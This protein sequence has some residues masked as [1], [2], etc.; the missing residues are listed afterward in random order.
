MHRSAS[1]L[2]VKRV[3]TATAIGIASALAC[4]SSLA[5][6]GTET[7]AS[8]AGGAEV[9][10]SAT[11][12]GAG[13]AFTDVITFDGLLASQLYE[14]SLDFSGTNFGA[15]AS[16]TLTGASSSTVNID[17]FS[18]FVF[19]YLEATALSSGSGF[20]LTI[21]APNASL[22]SQYTGTLTASLVPEPETYAMMLA[23]I[24]V[25]GFV[26]ARRRRMM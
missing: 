11:I 25:V 14:V 3:L 24:G 20:Q 21:S 8:T 12:G 2:G 9:F 1:V 23:G 18:K 7:F 4:G 13:L 15:G 26:A 10:G 6:N 17:T 22:G 16:A 19:V 5:A